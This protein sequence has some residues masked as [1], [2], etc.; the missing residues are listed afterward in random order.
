MDSQL[1]PDFNPPPLPPG[2]PPPPP[3]NRPPPIIAP[4]PAPRPVRKGNGWRVFAIILVVLLALSLVANLRHAVLAVVGVKMKSSH[5]T[6]PQLEEVTVRDDKA[7]DKIVV[8]PIEGVIRCLTLH[9]SEGSSKDV[10]EWP[11]FD[12]GWS[13]LVPYS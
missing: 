10:E 2:A 6:G 9:L 3:L 5:S 13:G 4:L 11:G 8:V 12:R 7:S 1:P